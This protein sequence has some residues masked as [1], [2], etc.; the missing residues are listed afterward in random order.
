V[1]VRILLVATVVLWILIPAAAFKPSDQFLHP[2]LASAIYHTYVWAWICAALAYV[3]RKRCSKPAA[4]AIAA[5]A[6]LYYCLSYVLMAFGQYTGHPLD[7]RFALDNLADASITLFNV[8]GWNTAGILIAA[9]AL[10]LAFTWIVL[11]IQSKHTW[12]FSKQP[13]IWLLALS[14]ALYLAPPTAGYVGQSV[15]NLVLSLRY[16]AAV[17]PVSETMRLSDASASDEN[18]F[19]LQLESL[20]ALAAFGQAVVEGRH[21]QDIYTPHLAAMATEGVLFPFAWGNTIQTARSS[22]AVL[23][24]VSNNVGQPLSFRPKE[25][26]NKCLPQL[27]RERG[28]STIYFNG[29]DDL[30]FANFADFARQIGFDESLG[31]QLMAPTQHS[32]QW[33]YDEREFF[34]NIFTYLKDKH[35][36]PRRLFVHIAVSRNHYPFTDTHPEA[37][38]F[39]AP[40]RF[41]EYYLNS[42]H[43]EDESLDV[44]WKEFKAYAGENSHLFV[45]GDHSWPVGMSGSILNEQGT[46]VEN[47]AVPILY[48]PPRNRRHEIKTGM[49]PNTRVSQ[50]DIPSTVLELTGL[51][52]GTNSFAPI[53]RGENPISYEDCQILVQPYSAASIVVVRGNEKYTYQLSDGTLTRA[54]LSENLQENERAITA[55]GMS[56]ADFSAQYNCDRY[57]RPERLPSPRLASAN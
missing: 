7:A 4:Y 37:R 47:F 5:T 57:R 15:S 18:V 34:R 26:S 53:L 8:L 50:S 14:L 24:G 19:F 23:C 52:S 27:L 46:D 29:F 17:Q 33:G 2:T 41:I 44:F 56:Y 22:E 10:W 51:G 30:N 9:V 43:E 54:H 40:G 32:R 3:Q 35:S 21:Y 13:G 49:R 11:Q 31:P 1:K 25:I 45:F 20:N 42:L 28:L 48:V 6:G 16:H 38:L 36:S 39:S 55:T 12:S